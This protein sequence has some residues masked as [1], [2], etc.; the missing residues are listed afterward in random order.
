MKDGVYHKRKVEH[1][2]A[3]SA[4]C[5]KWTLHK[6]R[7][8]FA[9]SQVQDGLDIR[10]LQVLLG[11]KNIATTEKYLKSLRME[12]LRTHVESSTLAGLL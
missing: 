4:H 11:H 1:Q 6:F 7:H 8:S 12:K 2:C 10:T 9:T 3:T 5:R